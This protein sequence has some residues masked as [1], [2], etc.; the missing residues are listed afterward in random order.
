MQLKKQ[1]RDT[2][3]GTCP[4]RG[5]LPNLLTLPWGVGNTSCQGSKGLT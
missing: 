2:S 4:R 1:R 5:L 3:Q